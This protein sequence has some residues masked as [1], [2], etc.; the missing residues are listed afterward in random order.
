[1]SASRANRGYPQLLNSL[2]GMVLILVAALDMVVLGGIGWA[3]WQKA[4]LSE[5]LLQM[6]Q[7]DPQQFHGA[8]QEARDLRILIS[9][10]RESMAAALRS[11]PDDA[12]LARYV[13]GLRPAAEAMG[14]TVT[15]LSPQAAQF[16]VAPVRRF[17]VRAK[18]TWADLQRFLGH[19]TQTSPATCRL[20]EL[21]LREQGATPELSLELVALVRPPGS[22]DAGE[23]G[24]PNA[25]TSPGTSRYQE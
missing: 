5:Y 25:G 8:Q 10:S 9:T 12:D 14:I 19:I 6:G 18:G 3:T 24:E 13:S 11:L 15:E 21:S 22:L 23:S 1:V 16:G 17:A 2:L 4:R 7:E 20:E